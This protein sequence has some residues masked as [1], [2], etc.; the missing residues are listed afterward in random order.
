M[1]APKL[2]ERRRRFVDRFLVHGNATRA[3]EEAGFK[4]PNVSGTKLVKDSAVRAAIKAAQKPAEEAAWATREE[5]LMLLTGIARGEIGDAEVS[6]SGDLV[7]NDD[8]SPLQV[9][10]VK[11]RIKAMEVMARM[12]GENLEK[13]EHSGPGGG[14]IPV[15]TTP[16]EAEAVNMLAAA[17]AKNPVMAKQLQA[18]LGKLLGGG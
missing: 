18:Q 13:R 15:G 1:T 11:D 9:T 5:R 6:L 3:A 2:T 10:K 17:A 7:K 16:S 4:Q 8:G 14:P 12:L